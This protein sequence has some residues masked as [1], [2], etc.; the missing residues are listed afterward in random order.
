M[1]MVAARIRTRA[2]YRA[3]AGLAVQVKTVAVGQAGQ[4]E[5]STLLIEMFDD[6]G[7]AEA[8]GNIFGWLV[9]LEHIDYFEPDQIIDP[10]FD[11]QGAAG[12]LAVA[13][14]SITVTCPGFQAVWV[15]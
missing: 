1:R 2:I 4:G 7:F 5:D 11:G 6:A 3:E 10:H 9:A 12:G 15:S 13:T 8:L 14:E